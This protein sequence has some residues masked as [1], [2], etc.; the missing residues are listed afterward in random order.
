ML[1]E[2]TFLEGL[3]LISPKVFN[4]NRG[5]FLET[6]N[7]KRYS[8]VLGLDLDFVQDNHSQSSKEVLR[9]L[10]YQKNNPQGKL[11]R[12]VSG[13]IFDVAV[14]IRKGSPTFAKWYGVELNQDNKKQLW[15]PPGFA[16]GFLTLSDSADLEYKC[17]DYYDPEDEGCILWNDPVIGI[18]WKIQNPSL[19]H[20]DSLGS[21]I[22]EI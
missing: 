6:F 18:E 17:T 13:S 11:V 4:D 20:K 16:H 19:S 12:V 5:F 15:I 10:H 3:I 21:L 8:D 7:S 22:E 2:E 1:I 14:D 9:G